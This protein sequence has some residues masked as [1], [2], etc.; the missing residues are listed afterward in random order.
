MRIYELALVLRTKLSDKDRK[1]VVDTLKEWLKDMKV[2]KEEEFGQK[3]LAYP[4]KKEAAGYYLTLHLEGETIPVDV[5]RRILQT[6]EV[7]RHLLIRTK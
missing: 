7:L 3:P 2:T 4:I 6:D 5:E 1:K